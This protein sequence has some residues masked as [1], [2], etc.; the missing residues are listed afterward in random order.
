MGYDIQHAQARQTPLFFLLSFLTPP[1][2]IS[3][4]CL[5]NKS[6]VNASKR[7]ISVHPET[8]LDTDAVFNSERSNFVQ[9]QAQFR[10]IAELYSPWLPAGR[11]PWMARVLIKGLCGN[12]LKYVAQA[13]K[14]IDAEIAQKG[15]FRM[16][17]NY[18]NEGTDARKF[19]D[20]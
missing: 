11:G 13:S 18:R 6:K 1:I 2:Y 12:V 16:K 3:I 10:R 17:T 7:L 8:H 4:A 14:K 9:S 5:A 19:G 15:T 20:W